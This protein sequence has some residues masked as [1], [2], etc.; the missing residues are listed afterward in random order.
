MN[1]TEKLIW[2]AVGGFVVAVV[3]GA[4]R[5]IARR[6]TEKKLDRVVLDSE[7]TVSA[8]SATIQ[9]IGC[10]GLLL[11]VTCKSDRPAKIANTSLS[12]ALT[13]EDLASFEAGF[14]FPFGQSDN[15]TLPPPRLMIQLLPTAKPT[16]E[17]GFVLE[18]DDVARFFFPI[19]VPAL[20][21]FLKAPSEDVQISATF[22]DGSSEL[23][24]QGLSVQQML[25]DVLDA[26]GD[27]PLRLKVPMS[28][29]ITVSAEKLP[30]TGPMVGKVNPKSIRF[31]EPQEPMIEAEF[32]EERMEKCA[33][34]FRDIWNDWGRNKTLRYVVV[35]SRDID[36][37]DP[38][39]AMDVAFGIG[40]T[41]PV[42]TIGLVDLLVVFTLLSQQ[43]AALKSIRTDDQSTVTIRSKIT[44]QFTRS[45][46]S[47]LL[48]KIAM[49]KP[50][51][52]PNCQD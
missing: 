30:A 8:E 45:Q 39:Q 3:G 33:A 2:G 23:L 40:V 50:G 9:H 46:A 17:N 7:L 24:K 4:I 6:V 36:V 27:I 42:C 41:K 10:P 16:N 34:I 18:R 44:T 1:D 51:G 14:Q 31:G 32:T 38:S 13:P 11:S 28:M 26:Y 49:S 37:D 5:Y 21:L 22:F 15:L 43:T 52:E 19:A 25:R 48:K 29:N 12:V 35:P 20:P 47:A